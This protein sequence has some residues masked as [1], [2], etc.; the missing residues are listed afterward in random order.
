MKES[1]IL[2]RKWRNGFIFRNNE[3]RINN[4]KY[5]KIRATESDQ[6]L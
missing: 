6:L 1:M 2:L 5:K 4:G 3:K